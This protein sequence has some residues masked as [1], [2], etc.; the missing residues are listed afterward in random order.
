MPTTTFPAVVALGGKTATGIRVPP[1]IVAGL[2]CTRRPAVRVTIGDHTYRT[3]VAVMG[4]DFMIALSGENRSR[5]GV[6]AGDRVDALSYS[7]KWWLVTGI[8]EARPRPRGSDASPRSE[9]VRAVAT[10]REVRAG[11]EMCSGSPRRARRWCGDAPSDH[12]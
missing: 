1:E 8:E 9:R 11:A 7:R 12:L 10:L 4:G 2:S 3:T 5:A 6:A